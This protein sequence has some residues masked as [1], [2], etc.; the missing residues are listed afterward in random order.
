MWVDEDENF[1]KPV[2]ISIANS[3]PKYLHL[4]VAV[5]IVDKDRKA[6]LQKRAKTKKVNPGIWI[7]TAAGHVTYGE[8]IQETA[9]RE[10]IEEMGITCK[11]QYIFK[12]K[13]KLENETHI[14]YWFIG[15]YSRDE[16]KPQ[17]EE[18]EEFCWLSK[19][20]FG[21]FNNSHE[22]SNRT[23]SVLKRYWSGEWDSLLKSSY[24]ET[25]SH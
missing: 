11:L 24:E 7:T 12:E 4:E 2:P 15:T 22:L 6:L 13:V 23:I 19:N 9:S 1:I 3:D 20:E 17:R 10:L 14:A 25:F 8:T 18:V 5:L 21:K 16:I